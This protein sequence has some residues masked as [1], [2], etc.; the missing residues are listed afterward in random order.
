[1]AWTT[2]AALTTSTLPELDANFSILTY[3]APVA[4][5]ASGTNTIALTAI[6]G[7][8]TIAAYQQN[9]QLTAIASA[10]NS[11]AATAALGSLSVLPIYKDTQTGPA[12]LTGSEIVQNCQ[13]TLRYDLALNGGGGGFHLQTG[14]GMLNGQTVTLNSLFATS[15]SLTGVFTGV[16]LNL[17][18]PASIAGPLNGSSLVLSG[19]ASVAGPFNGTSISLAGND[20]LVR[21]NSTL[22][23]V[24]L[25]AL[26]PQAGAL[27]TISLAGTAINDNILVGLP[28]LGTSFSLAIV[29]AF[30]SAS[31]SVVL[32]VFNAGT[33][34]TLAASTLTFRLTDLGF[35]T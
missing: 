6:N 13:F 26:T 10:T 20:A 14:S 12:A 1:M 2:F 31:G 4:C 21:L 22:A 33:A 27:H 15:A 11:G 16:S 18:G 23:T 29:N 24:T 34:V 30:V 8:T 5:T 32:N 9:M 3:L 25:A 17:S 19:S 28:S 7:G 35:V